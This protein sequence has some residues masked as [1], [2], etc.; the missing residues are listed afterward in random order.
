MTDKDRPTASMLILFKFGSADHLRVF[1]EDGVMHMRTLS[2]FA[3]LETNVS[4]N[5]RLEGSSSMYQPKDVGDFTIEH[6][7]IGKHTV[8]PKELRGRLSSK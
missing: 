8:D 1:R 5:D 2:Y 7:L 6:P 3:N 4:R